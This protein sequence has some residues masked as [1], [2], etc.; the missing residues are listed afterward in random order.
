[1][2]NF[3]LEKAGPPLI[4][5]GGRRIINS[6]YKREIIWNLILSELNLTLAS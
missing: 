3:F 2:T 5:G 6:F 4:A 1:M